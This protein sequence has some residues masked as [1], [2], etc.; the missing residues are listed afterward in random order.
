MTRTKGKKAVKSRTAPDALVKD[1]A[2]IAK[3]V[4]P[5]DGADPHW[6]KTARAA[7][8]GL[9]V[10]VAT[11]KDSGTAPTRNAPAW[12]FADHDRAAPAKP[13]RRKQAKKGKA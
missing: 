12:P 6:S 7:V 5:E 2:W 4:I 8:Q 11:R 9:I 10:Q 13:G 3:A 1:A